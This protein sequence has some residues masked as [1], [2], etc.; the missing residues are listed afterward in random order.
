VSVADAYVELHVDGDALAGE[1]RTSVREAGAGADKDVDKVGSTFGERM[2]S[3]FTTAFQKRMGGTSGGGSIGKYFKDAFGGFNPKSMM[4]PAIVALV[5]L[6]TSTISALAGTLTALTGAVVQAGSS[7]IA[8]VGI[9]GALAQGAIVAKIA[10][11]GFGKAIGGDR[12][13]MKALSPAAQAAAKAV[14]GLKDEWGAVKN[15]IQQR[16]FEGLAEPIARIGEKLLP[17]LQQQLG[18]TGYVLNGII[19][20]VIAFGTSRSFVDRFGQAMWN[21]NRILENLG[22]AIVPVLDGILNLFLAIQ[23]AAKRLSG[24]VGGVAKSFAD[25]AGKASTANKIDDFLKRAFASASKLWRIFKSLGTTIINV[26]SAATPAGG[27]LLGTLAR[28][29]EQ[30]ADF[31]GKASSKNAIATWAKQGIDT[32]KSLFNILGEIGKVLL[33]LFNP[34]F[35]G[36]VFSVFQSAIPIVVSL[37]NTIKDALMPIFADISAALAENGPKFAAL[38]SAL[39]PLLKGVAAVIGQIISQTISGLGAI[40]SFITPVVKIISNILGPLLVK[41]APIIAFLILAFTNWGSTIVKLVPYIGKFIAPLVRLYEVIWEKIGPVVSWLGKLI[42]KVLPYIAKGFKLYF[43]IASKV[44]TTVFSVIAKVIGVYLKIV[45]AIVKKAWSFVSAVTVPVFKFLAKFISTYVKIWW[46]VVST[47]VQFIWKAVAKYFGLVKSVISVVVR[48]I[49]AIVKRY[50]GIVRTVIGAVASFV[51][52]VFVGPM[53]ALWSVISSGIGR[54]VD[55]FHSMPSKILSLATTFL[56]AGKTLGSKIITGLW[57]GLRA[58]GGFI[59]DIAGA[60]KSAINSA[61]HLPFT[62]HGPGPLP[63]FTIP[64]FA[65]GGIAPGGLALVGERGPEIV[66]LP[67]GS[68]V[69][70]AQDTRNMGGN[71]RSSFPKKVI[72]RIGSKDFEAYVSEVSDGRIAAADSLAWQG[73]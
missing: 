52:K 71:D 21:N 4:I 40:A 39:S 54:V 46:K 26:F 51:G 57:N 19:K 62:I 17:T 61:L 1:V 29:S 25:M 11:A 28:L 41:F 16:V 36:G 34:Q 2:A 37:V 33:P 50:F 59:S 58:V 12:D 10:F 69:H 14:K 53:K 13:A 32:T 30:L 63:D 6:A 70:T 31:T 3:K 67:R 65:K 68:N 38:F 64:A 56:N 48:V 9:V 20:K 35:A 73:A 8:L 5:P 27:K 55:L 18:G 66:D 22:K 43:G 15:E 44:A 47:V 45:M 23:P 24:S 72:L 42:G 49:S 7:G 60:I